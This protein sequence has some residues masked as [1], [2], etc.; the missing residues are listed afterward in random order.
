MPPKIFNDATRIADRVKSYNKSDRIFLFNNGSIIELK[1]YSDPQDT[2]SGKR[3]YLFVNEANGINWQVYSE[4]TL[5]TQR[6]IYIDYNPNAAFW[7]H[8]NLIGRDGVQLIISDHRH[9][10]FLDDSTHSKIEALLQVNEEQWK[11]YARG[12]TGKVRGLVSPIENC[13]TKYPTM[14]N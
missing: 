14:Q 10:P 5:R 8:D 1:S 11:V 9:N 12:I 2:K 13:V 7:V 6:R 3:D 4:I